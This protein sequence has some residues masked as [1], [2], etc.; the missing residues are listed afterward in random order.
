M[1]QWP[2]PNTGF[3][4]IKCK[5]KRFCGENISG[6]VRSFV[7]G[8][9]HACDRT[10]PCKGSPRFPS[11][12]LHHTSRLFKN[13]SFLLSSLLRRCF[14]EVA[15]KRLNHD[16]PQKVFSC[17]LYLFKC[18]L[19]FYLKSERWCIRV[20]YPFVPT[21][22]TVI[23]ILFLSSEGLVKHSRYAEGNV[24]VPPI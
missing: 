23:Y 18:S 21:S 22:K 13:V 11:P 10:R 12:P 5:R 9:S 16:N 19:L 7:T 6:W 24:R 14:V 4:K 8:S 17:P 1:L 15:K 3:V 20:T 2:I